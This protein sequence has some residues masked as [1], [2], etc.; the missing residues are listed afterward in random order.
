MI[1]AKKERGYRLLCIGFDWSLLQRGIS[2]ILA[3]A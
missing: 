1:Q 2:S 3:A